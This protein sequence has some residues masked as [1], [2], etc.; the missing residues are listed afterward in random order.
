M[1]R[2]EVIIIL[3]CCLGISTLSRGQDEALR[4]YPTFSI[5][6]GFPVGDFRTSYSGKTQ[7]GFSSDLL[8]V[9]VRDYR[10]WQIGV[11]M[12]Y[13]NGMVKK[14]LWK[15]IEV[16]TRSGFAKL[17]LFKSI[18][19]SHNSILRICNICKS[20]MIFSVHIGV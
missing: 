9:P 2:L 4:F 20:L 17:N 11:Q 16:E 18:I 19:E 13:L 1:M 7:W 10:F 15:G 5:L 8:F 14:D 12:E 6:T 3:V